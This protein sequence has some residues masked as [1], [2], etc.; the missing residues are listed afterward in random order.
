MLNKVLKDTK[1]PFYLKGKKVFLHPKDID[2]IFK[3]APFIP[4]SNI[5]A[6][7]PVGRI[8]ML[9]GFEL[10]EQDDIQILL[11]AMRGKKNE[12]EN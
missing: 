12:K 8:G 7:H 1:K 3:V 9:Y 10:Y 2:I 11:L 4:E 6:P 5:P